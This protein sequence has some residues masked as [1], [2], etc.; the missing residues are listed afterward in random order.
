MGYVCCRKKLV[1]SADQST[2]NK[3]VQDTSES[4]RRAGKLGGKELLRF[5][6]FR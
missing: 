4:D 6:Q 2:P 3:Y 5:E 1:R